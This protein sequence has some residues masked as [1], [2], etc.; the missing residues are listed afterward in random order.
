MKMCPFCGN[1]VKDNAI[2]CPYC[3]SKLSLNDRHKVTININKFLKTTVICIIFLIIIFTPALII[4]S[5]AFPVGSGVKEHNNKTICRKECGI[6]S[7]EFT[8]DENYCICDNG[9]TYNTKSGI[10][11][12]NINSALTDKVVSY[13][14]NN[15]D[16]FEDDLV[17]KQKMMVI[18][19]SE[20][21]YEYIEQINSLVYLF[22]NNNFEDVSFHYIEL[23]KL[24]DKDIARLNEF[25]NKELNG[26]IYIILIN[27]GKPIYVVTS[28]N[29]FN[30][31][32]MKGLLEQYFY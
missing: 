28:F 15:L 25:S 3:K 5:Y 12:F 23:D 2:N 7:Y 10:Y 16:K 29:A 13:R 21:S 8:S 31:Y 19:Q 26:E 4:M 24:S 14:E 1:Q 11:M 32:K 18:V 22:E 27:N 20:D 30:S 9:D 17:N 6:F